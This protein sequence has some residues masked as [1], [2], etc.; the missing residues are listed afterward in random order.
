MEQVTFDINNKLESITI[1]PKNGK[2]KIYIR[3]LHQ[4]SAADLE[5]KE[6]DMV[7][8][9]FNSSLSELMSVLTKMLEGKLRVYVNKDFDT[10]KD[11]K[12]MRIHKFKGTFPG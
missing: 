10:S 5:I 6:N 4:K 8:I 11:F 2:Y 7:S 3:Q 9:S 1:Y 12:G